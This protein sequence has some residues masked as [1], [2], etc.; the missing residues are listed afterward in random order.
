MGQP[1]D[2]S[3][4]EDIVRRASRRLKWQAALEGAAT[5]TIPAAAAALVA[6]FLIRA[7]LID[8]PLGL[9]LLCAAPLLAAG[10]ALAGALR[11]E[12]DERVA[13]RVDRASNLSDRL[14]TALAFQRLLARGEVVETSE[15]DPEVTG[16]LMKAAIADGIAAVPRARIEQAT[17]FRRP[18]DGRIA[19][20]F[21]A[22]CA[23][24]GGLSLPSSKR[25]PQLHA[26][27]PDHGAAGA[28]IV[29]RGAN[30]L[31]GAERASQ[32][33]GAVVAGAAELPSNASVFIGSGAII[34]PVTLRSWDDGSITVVIPA[35][36]VIG[37]T[38]LVAYLGKRELG[39]VPFEVVD[40]KDA[41]FHKEDAVAIEDQE[42]EYIRSLVADI[43]LTA[44]QDQAK[45]LDDYAAKVEKLLE[46]AERGELTKEQLLREMEKAKS[47][48]DQGAE[49]SE[50]E[51]AKEL[52]KTGDELAKDELT[53]ELGKALQ[54]NDLEQAK[55]EMEKLADKLEKEE[56]T[57]PEKQRLADKMQKVAE[58]FEKR[59][60]QKKE[61]QQKQQQELE[62]QV[63]RLQKEKQEAKN[64]EER[65]DAERR[66]QKKKDELEKLQKDQEERDQSAQREAVKRL[67]KDMDKAGE[68]LQKKGQNQDQQQ[69]ASRNLKDAARETGRVQEEQRKQTAQKKVASQMEDLKEAMRRAKQKG[70]KG[71]QSPFAKDQKQSDFMK[72]ARGQQGS[73]TA[74]KPGQQ[75]QGQQGQGKGQKGQGQQGQGGQGQDPGGTTWGE[76]HDDNL[77]GDPTDKGGHTKDEDLQ[78]VQGKGPSRRQT[79]LAAAQK[80]FATAKY[81]EVYTDYKRIVEEVMRSEKVPSSYKY[82]VKRY[83]NQIKPK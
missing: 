42:L 61:Q 6:I 11:T 71:P 59:Q 21:L 27:V 20:A 46:Q 82:Y 65:E 18:R 36:A 7:E 43:R 74:W 39:R 73:R 35:H 48:L 13:R 29:L 62:E 34:A 80:G 12:S 15:G 81:Q 83:F 54:K 3:P 52:Q 26:A 4:I 51:L 67:H 25:V 38:Q 2:I 69:E 10:G 50:D 66:L 32:A 75:G 49:P 14:S 64:D 40:A 23:L 17:P 55:K 19:L 1:V 60:E 28:E 77:T 37:A 9:A 33:G 41:R 78:G 22:V 44:K 24:A 63:R 57:Q 56:L 31:V 16:E 58:Q 53:K 8:S 68:Q 45:E 72:R 70:N 79:I 30:L 5:W 76:G 47:E